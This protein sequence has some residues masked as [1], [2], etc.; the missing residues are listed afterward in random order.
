MSVTSDTTQSA[1]SSGASDPLDHLESAMGHYRFGNVPLF[2][3]GYGEIV[4][5]GLNGKVLLEVC[6]GFGDLAAWLAVNYPGVRVV[7][8][9]QFEGTVQIARSKHG[10]LPAIQFLTGDALNLAQFPDESFDQVIGQATMHHLSNN[11]PRASKEFARVLKPGG[12][13][14]F[15][16]EPLG[17]NP[18]IAMFRALLNTRSHSEDES[19]LFERSIRNFAVNFHRH[20]V[21]YFNLLSF[22]AKGLPPGCGT[23]RVIN[24]LYRLDDAL[25]R[26]FPRL[27][28]YAGC[29]N[30]IYWK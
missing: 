27:R 24:G 14:I 19:F 11:L 5:A 29:F 9:D 7:A 17:H 6:A 21:Q 1:G 30:A 4:R 26:R 2:R 20:E 25:F 3:A 22:W 15:I 16:Y 18:V 8:I 12:K 10:H 13:C 23:R 28:K